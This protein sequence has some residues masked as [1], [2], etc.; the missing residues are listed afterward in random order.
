E[1]FSMLKDSG[2][3][4]ITL[5]ARY[6]WPLAAWIQHLTAFSGGIREAREML[7]DSFDITS[8]YTEKAIQSFSFFVR[9]G[10]VIENYL[11]NDWPDAL[12]QLIDG[13][14]AF[15]LLSEN[16]ATSIPSD[17]RNRIGFIP[18]PQFSDDEPVPWRVGSLIYLGVPSS[19]QYHDDAL[20]VLKFLTSSGT[21]SRLSK[22]LFLP[23]FEN[24]WNINEKAKSAVRVME[25]IPSITSRTESPVI[26]D[27]KN[28][29]I[30]LTE[31]K[32]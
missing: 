1:T 2:V 19:S 5:G 18:F 11:D 15:C 9:K 14:A 17:I 3:T 12:R 21:T 32:K 13:N 28:K 22:N 7:S 4:P 6:G 30:E 20:K 8:P 23:F 10:W 31:I 25:T 27:I 29:I 26:L 16:L 24:D